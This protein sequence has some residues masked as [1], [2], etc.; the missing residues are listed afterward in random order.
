MCLSSFPFLAF[1]SGLQ[2]ALHGHSWL[3][4]HRVQQLWSMRA[5]DSCGLRCTKELYRYVKVL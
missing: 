5:V 1:T 3:P 2:A 4:W